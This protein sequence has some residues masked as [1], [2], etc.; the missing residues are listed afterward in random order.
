MAYVSC[1]GRESHLANCSQ[2]ISYTRYCSHREDAGVRCPGTIYACVMVW[3]VG[4]HSHAW[5]D[6][7]CLHNLMYTAFTGAAN[8]TDGELRLSGGNSSR[9]GRVEV[10]Y[11]RQWGTVCDDFWGTNDAKVVCRQLG[12]SS[13]GKSVNTAV[14]CHDTNTKMNLIIH[15]RCIGP[16]QCL[17]W[18]W[19]WN[20]TPGQCWMYW[21]RIKAV[22]LLQFWN[23]SLQFKLWP[24]WWCWSDMQW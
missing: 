24:W 18:S 6:H 10:C 1:S 14:C 11:E 13:L 22:R 5:C 20:H 17:L 9:Q 4:L 12:F 23:R 8:C 19:N 2:S 15:F 16:Y 3:K 7:L 21:R